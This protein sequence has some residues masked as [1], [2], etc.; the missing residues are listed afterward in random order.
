MSSGRER[1]SNHL[2]QFFEA[3]PP[4]LEAQDVAE[5]LGMSR[6]AVYDLLKAGTI[7][8]YKLGGSW[9][10]LRDELR[11]TIEAGSNQRRRPD[12][13]QTIH[14]ERQRKAEPS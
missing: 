9:I 5:L 12:D 11:D 1:V 6:K 13:N 7:P 2:N 14:W 3:L 10:I 8:A 4:L